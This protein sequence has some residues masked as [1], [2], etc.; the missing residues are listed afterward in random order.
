M[1]EPVKK[2][3]RSRQE[4]IIF[5]VCGGLSEYF[6]VD[7]SIIRVIF[8]LLAIAGSLGFWLY[9]FLT[10]VAPLSPINGEVVVEIKNKNK[11]S[12]ELLGLLLLC[13]GVILIMQ[14]FLS[15]WFDWHLFVSVAIVCLGVYLLVKKN[16]I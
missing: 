11:N 10:I 3:Y 13:I 6:N 16:K 8:I 5:G 15:F 1:S 9:L 2:F 14:K 7:V 4:R 12:R